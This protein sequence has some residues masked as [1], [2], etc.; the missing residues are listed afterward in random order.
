MLAVLHVPK[1]LPV[2]KQTIEKDQEEGNKVS[3]ISNRHNKKRYF[4]D[5]SIEELVP[6]QLK[7]FAEPPMVAQAHHSHQTVGHH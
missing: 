5:L 7:C 4:T 1:S 6:N 3:D 2:Q